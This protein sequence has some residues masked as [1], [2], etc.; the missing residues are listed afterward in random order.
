RARLVAACAMCENLLGRHEAAHARLVGALA[1][2]EDHRSPAAADLQVELAADALYDSDFGAMR[3]FSQRGL[4]T[5]L[6]HGETGLA[7][8][9][10]AVALGEAGERL[11]SLGDDALAGRLDAPYYLGFAEY[12]GE[13][14]EE[15]IRHLRRGIALSRAVGQ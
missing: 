11:D 3:E 9:A 15:A 12:F 2:V 10:G 4:A 14:Y 13:R 7:V 8:V 1:G 5:A 6:E